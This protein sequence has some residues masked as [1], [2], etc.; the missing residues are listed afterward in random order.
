[1]NDL[2]LFNNPRFGDVRTLTEDG[3]TLFCG[4]D[5][6]RALGYTN[7][8]DALARH[9]KCVVKR[10]VPHPQSPEKQ[11]EMSFIP[12]GDLYR[13]ITHSKLPD[14]EKFE[15]WV[16]EDILP[17]IR[18]NGMY[19]TPEKLAEMLL[20]PDAM[21]Q[22]LQ[23]LKAEQEKRRALEAQAEADKP[24]VLFSDAVSAS[25]SSILVGDLA[26]LLRQNG[27]PI[28]QN[29]LFDRLRSDGYLMRYGESRNLPTQRAMEQGLFEVKE[30]TIANPD[31]SI[32]VT[33]TTKV[34]G[35]GQVY[36]VNRYLKEA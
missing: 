36:F 28:G 7:A 35:K 20:N 31:G 10:D 34:T 3:N 23:A 15:R 33:K 2:Q 26:K 25:S 4:S 6:A 29:R 17:S 21:I 16:F 12:E 22:T 1:M 19:A 11:I 8:R 18:R 5:V 24:K 27:V 9:C 30:T 14:A 13:L 32:R